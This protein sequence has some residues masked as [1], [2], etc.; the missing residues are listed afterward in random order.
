MWELVRLLV[1]K[2]TKVCVYDR[3]G[4]GF[5]DRAF[6]VSAHCLRSEVYRKEADERDGTETVLFCASAEYF[7]LC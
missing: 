5:S 2:R 4:L 3:A 7:T 6:T 1:A